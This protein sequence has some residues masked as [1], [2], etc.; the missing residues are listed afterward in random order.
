MAPLQDLALDLVRANA[1]LGEALAIRT[2]IFGERHLLTIARLSSKLG[3]DQEGGRG[4]AAPTRRGVGDGIH[5]IEVINSW[6]RTPAESRRSAPS[7]I[8]AG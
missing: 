1:F 8:S 3:K 6:P 2:T 7:P 4:D 5:S